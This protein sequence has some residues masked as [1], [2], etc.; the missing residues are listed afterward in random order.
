[1]ALCPYCGT[2]NEEGSKYCAECGAPIA[3]VSRARREDDVAMVG[4]SGLM[5]GQAARQAR[6]EAV[7]EEDQLIGARAYNGVLLGVLLWGF[8]INVLLCVYVG[9]VTR[10]I[11]SGVFLIGYL[12]CAIV[13]TVI[14]GRS[15]KPLVSFLGYNL[16]VLPFGLA[17]AAAVT[18]YGGVDSAAVKDAFLYTMLISLGMGAAALAFPSLFD[19]LG[20]A[21]LG[22]LI[23]AVICELLLLIFRVEQSVTDWIVAGMFCLYIGYDVHRSQQFAKTLDNAVDCALDIY[24]DIANLFLRLLRL[25]SRKNK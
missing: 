10:Y 5:L 7:W 12:V 11:P 13:G 19:K 4:N 25:L 20:G 8:L 16:V 17:I 1:M 6:L 22:V 14:A 18:A 3:S 21:L 2:E 15:H 24:L 23:G 9:D